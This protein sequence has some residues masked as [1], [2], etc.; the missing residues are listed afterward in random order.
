MN[1]IPSRRAVSADDQH[2]IEQFLYREAAL[3]DHREYLAWLGLLTDDVSYKVMGQVIR[4]A[5]IGNIELDLIDED[6]ASLRMRVE[7]I[8]TPRLTHAENPPT[9]ARRFISNVQASH[10]PGADEFSVEANL[11]IY[12]NRASLPDGAL[13]AGERHDV[14][15]RVDGQL[16][17]ARRVVRLDQAVFGGSMTMLF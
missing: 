17:L 1:D 10:G 13:Y 14:L 4:D 6:P 12:R 15:R 2:L 3:L 5:A 16:R 9:M 7:Q 11:L 8:A